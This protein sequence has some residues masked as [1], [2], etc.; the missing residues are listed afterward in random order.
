MPGRN[1]AVFGIYSNTA[2][3]EGAIDTLQAAGFRSSDI[4]VLFPE[5]VG[6]KE[7]TQEKRTKAPEGAAAGGVS[8]AVLGGTLGW[9]AG[10]GM[11]AIP[12]VGP[13]IAAGPILSAL[14]G[15]GIGGTVAGITGALIGTGIPEYEA[16]KYV[17]RVKSGGI[18]MSVQTDDGEWARKARSI[19]RDTGAEDISLT[20]QATTDYTNREGSIRRSASGEGK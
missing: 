19:L 15:V 8:G 3:V 17:G 20:G 13:L 6:N 12:G 2:E 5:N 4:S 16:R 10:M 9:L 14:A 1:T 18:L 11:I 7:L